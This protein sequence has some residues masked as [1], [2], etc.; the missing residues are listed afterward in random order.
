M[1]EEV[2]EWQ[3]MWGA[4]VKTPVD[5]ADDVLKDAISYVTTEMQKCENFESDG[6]QM[7]QKIKE[8]MDNE[9]KPNW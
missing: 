7:V 4:K 5:M 3:I 2:P 1:S 9:W 8:H 6:E